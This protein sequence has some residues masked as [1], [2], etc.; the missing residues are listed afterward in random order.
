M[1]KKLAIVVT[2]LALVVVMM[3]TLCACGSTW[4]KIKKAYTSEGYHELELSDKIKETLNIDENDMKDVKVTIHV[5]S[6][7]ELPKEPS[8]ADYLKLLAAK[9]VIIAEY[10]N[11]KELKKYAEEHYTEE[12]KKDLEKA[13][14]D[15]QKLDNVNGNCVL[16]GLADSIWKGA[17]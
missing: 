10:N 17:K 16:M 8:A 11:M 6:T 14:E 13:W 15:F 12:Q 3:A 1:K 4:G 5:L 2:A 7:A 9:T